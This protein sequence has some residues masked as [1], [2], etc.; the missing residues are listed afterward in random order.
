MLTSAESH[1]HQNLVGT[2]W[3]DI[4]YS[5]VGDYNFLSVCGKAS[6]FRDEAR[7]D[8]YWNK[9]MEAWFEKGKDDSHIHLLKVATNAITGTKM[10]TGKGTL[11]L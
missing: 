4:A 8:K 11:D 6:I 5:H 9:L 2:N 1:L 10:D 3:I 7:I